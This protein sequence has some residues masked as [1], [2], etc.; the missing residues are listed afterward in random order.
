MIIGDSWAGY[1]VF[2]LCVAYVLL[3]V[4]VCLCVVY[5]SWAGYPVFRGLDICLW[6][7]CFVLFVL[8]LFVDR[9][10]AVFSFNVCGMFVLFS[11]NRFKLLHLQSN[12][13]THN[14]NTNNS[15]SI[16]T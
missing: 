15:A 14:I 6:F 3:F 1:P 9:S 8:M 2:C 10:V 7:V 16:N 13:N 12:N 4:Y 5:V 11:P